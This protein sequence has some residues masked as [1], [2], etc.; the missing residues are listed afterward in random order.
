MGRIRPEFYALLRTRDPRA[1]VILAYWF[2]LMCG[3]GGGGGGGVRQWWIVGRVKSECVAICSYLKHNHCCATDDPRIRA[4]LH[5]PARLC[6]VDLGP[7]WDL[8]GGPDGDGNGGE[9]GGI[10]DVF[11]GLRTYDGLQLEA[12]VEKWPILC[13][14]EMQASGID[15]L[16]GPRSRCPVFR[17]ALLETLTTA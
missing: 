8:G 2:A 17:K 14:E 15:E 10:D 16:A 5:F 1:L 12:V 4:L 6:G 3:G 9:G 7:D 13:Q 11:V